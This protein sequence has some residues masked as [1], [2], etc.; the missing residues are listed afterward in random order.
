[1]N[2]RKF[3][4]LGAMGCCG[5]FIPSCATNPITDRRQLL[6]YPESFINKQSAIFY[7]NFIRR[8]KISDDK[9]NTNMMIK[10]ATDMVKSVDSY[11]KKI[12]IPNPARDYNWEYNLIDS[13]QVNAFCAPGGKIAVYTGI[14][15]YTQNKDG[16]AAVMGHEI[17]HAVAKHSAERMSRAI[18]SETG[19][20]VANAA[21]GG[22]AGQVRQVF[23]EMTGQDILDLTIMRTHG[24]KQESE[25][26]YMGLAF[27]SMAGYD[28]NESV[29]LWK[30]MNEKKGKKEIP[31]FL[32]THPSSRTRILQ[33]RAW[34]PDIKI[35]FPYSL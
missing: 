12:K 11:F 17:A 21:T 19:F 9:K 10:I 3:I 8:S 20:A 35:E 25:A 33:L 29:R 16:L 34:I 31:Q 27:C 1:M 18:A 5:L 4:Q 32:S 24:R 22:A 15:K 28:L 26:D 23:S 2:R 6:I 13:P 30:R 7:K 14:L